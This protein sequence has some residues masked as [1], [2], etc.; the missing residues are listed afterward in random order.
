M[1]FE[2]AA[3]KAP[4]HEHRLAGVLLASAGAIAFSGKAI[5]VKLA[6]RYGVDAVTLIMYRMLF[7]LPLFLCLAAWAGRG[8][9]RLTWA[10]RRLLIG[11]GVTGYYLSSFLDFGGLEYINANLERLI[12]YLNP[13]FVLTLSVLLFRAKVLRQQ[14]L[15]LAVSYV[16]VL[17]VFA[18]DLSVSGSHV[19]LGSLLVLGSAFCYALY[20]VFSGQAVKRLG[21]LRITGVATSIAATVCIGQFFIL[22]PVSAMA[23]AHPVIWLSVLN[24]TLCTFLPVVLVMLAVER[25]GAT[26]VAQTGNIGPLSTVGLSILVLHEPLTLWLAIGTLLVL[27]GIWLLV[28]RPQPAAA[29]GR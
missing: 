8:R 5:V 28:R 21:A 13:T 25:V 29:G 1:T 7:A 19:A 15:A 2:A 4:A 12:L 16:G 22:R 6:Y 9:A 10:D 23:V 20:L 24:A 27:L 26:V 14:W 17:V 18:H 11:L 3:A